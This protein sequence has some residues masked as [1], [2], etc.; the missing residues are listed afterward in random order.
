[1]A[2]YS[3]LTGMLTVP[4]HLPI[5]EAETPQEAVRLAR[6]FAQKGRTGL[7]IG[8]NEK[9]EYFPVDEFAAKHGIR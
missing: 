6:E 1:M 9:A 8:D 2:R 4:R 3:V 7:K 5:A